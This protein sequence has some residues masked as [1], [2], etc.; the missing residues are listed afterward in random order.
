VE[1][2][3]YHPNSSLFPTYPFVLRMT[4]MTS[5]SYH[6]VG[7]GSVQTLIGELFY[8]YVNKYVA[9]KSGLYKFFPHFMIVNVD[10]FQ[11][12]KSIIQIFCLSVLA[13]PLN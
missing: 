4:H 3:F 11:R 10:Y 1:A 13:R 6:L 12:K 2:E 8:L 9:S 7:T 5:D